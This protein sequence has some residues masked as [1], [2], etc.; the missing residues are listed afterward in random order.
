MK[1]ALLFVPGGASG[2]ALPEPRARLQAR[3]AP[4]PCGTR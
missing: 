2:T 3:L 1:Q 4:G